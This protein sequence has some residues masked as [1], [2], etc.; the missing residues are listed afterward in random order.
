MRDTTVSVAAS[1]V[2]SVWMTSSPIYGLKY[3]R[4]EKYDVIV[5]VSLHEPHECH[6]HVLRQLCDGFA[7][8]EKE[9]V[10]EG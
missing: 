4:G 1:F 8:D 9:I 7:G 3:E 6:V 5:T 10:R 2:S